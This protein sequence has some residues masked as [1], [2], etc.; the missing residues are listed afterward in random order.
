MLKMNTFANA[1]KQDGLADKTERITDKTE[2]RL[3]KKRKKG[4]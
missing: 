4:E 1:S 3:A 2:A